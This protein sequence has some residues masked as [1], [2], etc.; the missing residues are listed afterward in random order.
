MPL[1]AF[2]SGYCIGLIVLAL[3]GPL[4]LAHNLGKPLYVRLETIFIFTQ[5]YSLVKHEI[6]WHFMSQKPQIT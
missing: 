6:I 1:E 5:A 2:F 3:A 4:Y